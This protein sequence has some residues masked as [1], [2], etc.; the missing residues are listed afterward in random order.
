METTNTYEPLL[1]IDQ[2]SLKK[3]HGNMQRHYQ[4]SN[5]KTNQ[6]AHRFKQLTLEDKLQ[7]ILQLPIQL[8]RIKVDVITEQGSYRGKIMHATNEY[9][10]M[11]LQSRK[12]ITIAKRDISD[13]QLISF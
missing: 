1:Y 4:S 2:P 13:I 9:I 5:I 10:S 3:P 8:P 6:K 7:Y 11:R 12:E